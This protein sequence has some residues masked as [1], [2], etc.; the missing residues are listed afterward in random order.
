MSAVVSPGGYVDRYWN[1]FKLLVRYS[2]EYRAV[3]NTL[4]GTIRMCTR[5]S[6]TNT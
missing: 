2:Q 3:K 1:A 6:S 5:M 4:R